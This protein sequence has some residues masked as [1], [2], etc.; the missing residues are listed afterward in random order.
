MIFLSETYLIC[1]ESFLPPPSPF[2]SLYLSPTCTF[3]HSAFLSS[4]YNIPSPS[5]SLLFFLLSF[6][7]SHSHP[8]PSTVL[9]SPPSLNKQSSMPFTILPLPT[10]MRLALLM[11]VWNWISGL[12]A[13]S[14]DSRPHYFR[15]LENRSSSLVAL[16]WVR[17]FRGITIK[18]VFQFD[19]QLAIFFLDFLHSILPK[20]T[21]GSMSYIKQQ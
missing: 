8:R 10:G 17:W 9:G 13:P 2:L 4:S 18:L 19:S 7:P 3:F 5:L 20:L 21:S 1:S 14:H 16:Q 11:P 6:P 15:F 12:D